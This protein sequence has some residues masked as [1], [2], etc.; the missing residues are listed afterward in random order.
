[1]IAPVPYLLLW[2]ASRLLS[3]FTTLPRTAQ[4]APGFYVDGVRPSGYTECVEAPSGYGYGPDDG[5]CW[6]DNPCTGD[7]PD[8]RR[9]SILVLCDVDEIAVVRDERTIACRRGAS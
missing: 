1:M 3:L 4:C 6:A 2:L 5:A 9:V 8:A 7:V